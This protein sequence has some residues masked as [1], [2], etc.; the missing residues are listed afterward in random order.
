MAKLQTIVWTRHAITSWNRQGRLQGRVDIEPEVDDVR[1][2]LSE[3][4]AQMEEHR[5]ESLWTSPLT[6]AWQGAVLLAKHLELP[7]YVEDDLTEVHFGGLEG[8]IMTSLP[9]S[10]I[11]DFTEWMRQP[12]AGDFEGVETYASVEARHTRILEKAAAEYR[13]VGI[14]GHTAASFSIERI[15]KNK[16]I[17]F[18]RL[19]GQLTS[20]DVARR[21][22]A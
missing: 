3:T 11:A 20:S 14:V 17:R 15:C 19:V 9:A 5:V 21:L 12:W 18:F 1:T 10:R 6:R 4:I 7:L 22:L 2:W 8:A 16:G 13:T